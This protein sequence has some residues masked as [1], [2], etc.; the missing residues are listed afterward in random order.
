M[1]TKKNSKIKEANTKKQLKPKKKEKSSEYYMNKYL[2]KDLFPAMFCPGCG[3]LNVLNYTIR[4]IDNLEMDIDNFVFVSGIGC[5]S[6][7]TAYMDADAIHTVH[8]RAIAFATGIKV[9]N[10]KLNVVV[11]TGDGDLAAIGMSHFMHA[12]RRNIGITVI[13]I[14]NENYGMTGGQV[15]P[16]TPMFEST[17]STPFGSIEHS[18]NLAG[19][20]EAAGASYVARWTSAHSLQVIKSIEKGIAKDGFSF[21]EIISSCPVGRRDKYKNPRE[22]MKFFINESIL[23]NKNETKDV[24]SARTYENLKDPFT[25]YGAREKIII[26]EF[27][28]LERPTYIQ[29]YEK[30]KQ[31][32][33]LEFLRIRKN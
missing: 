6:R 24:H 10:P 32:A 13:C 15:S 7:L 8:G 17:K 9:T 2:K 31:E 18:F 26:G 23:Y 29:L 28:N 11:F 33:K 27:A 1:K 22:I 30:L 12:I 5:S 4:A 21:I 3:N 20:A 14:N 16:T 19:I 25:L